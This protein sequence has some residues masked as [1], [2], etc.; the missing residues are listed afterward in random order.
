M[1]FIEVMSCNGKLKNRNY[2]NIKLSGGTPVLI[3]ALYHVKCV[4]VLAQLMPNR[5]TTIGSNLP[6]AS[7]TSTDELLVL[8]LGFF[9]HL[10]LKTLLVCNGAILRVCCNLALF[11]PLLDSLEDSF[12]V[13]IVNK[14]PVP[15]IFKI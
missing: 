13:V 10:P 8:C 3:E 5:T 7:C 14:L 4:T 2:G 9:C 12:Q 6:L 15:G 1:V 11:L